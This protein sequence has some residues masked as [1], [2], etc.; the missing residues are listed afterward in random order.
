MVDA[1][2]KSF[3]LIAGMENVNA[4]NESGPSASTMSRAC[5]KLDLAHMIIRQ[6]QWTQRKQENNQYVVTLSVSDQ[7]QL[8][9]WSIVQP[10]DDWLNWLTYGT[11]ADW[12]RLKL[13]RPQLFPCRIFVPFK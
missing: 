2:Q 1:V 3:E 5:M 13:I 11:I 10:I 7:S 8:I 6:Q 4:S 12:L 9:S